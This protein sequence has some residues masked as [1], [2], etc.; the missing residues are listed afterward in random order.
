VLKVSKFARHMT[1]TAPNDTVVEFIA[2]VHSQF[3]SPYHMVT[4]VGLDSYSRE[5]SAIK[6]V[7]W[8]KGER[9]PG[10][11]LLTAHE[12]AKAEGG[13]VITVDN[14]M[15]MLSAKP[16]NTKAA[17]TAWNKA[18]SHSQSTFRSF[19]ASPREVSF[20][21][22]D[23]PPFDTSVVHVSLQNQQR[24]KHMRLC[25]SH[26]ERETSPRHGSIEHLL[27]EESFGPLY[28]RLDKAAIRSPRRTSTRQK[29]DKW[30][31]R[32][33]TTSNLNQQIPPCLRSCFSGQ[34]KPVGEAIAART[35]KKRTTQQNVHE[36][37][38]AKNWS[39]TV[40]DEE[41]VKDDREMSV[42]QFAKATLKDHARMKR[43]RQ[44]KRW[45]HKTNDGDSEPRV[46]PG[47][48]RHSIESVASIGAFSS[49]S[50]A[51]NLQRRAAAG[52]SSSSSRTS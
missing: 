48:R 35:Y 51:S 49:F 20:D 26:P 16:R 42:E 45:G 3:N 11:A 34:E 9:Y 17:V 39:K 37:I 23:R 36:E 46:A 24:C 33:D 7:Q 29:E 31:N 47:G 14:L 5:I 13:T 52:S 22:R 38:W 50:D 4:E 2:W 43:Q 19:T 1:A 8:L 30:W 10:N 44:K 41:L 6:F 25:F 32:L 15:A 18:S 21:P 27:Q 12:V 28:R 40:H